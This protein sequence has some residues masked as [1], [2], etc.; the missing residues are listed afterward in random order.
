MKSVDKGSCMV[1]WDRLEHLAEAENH[2]N[3]NTTYKDVKFHEKVMAKLVEQS[4]K[5]FK[6][7]SKQ[8]ISYV[9]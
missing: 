6:K 8:N 9:V 2:L 5:M 3:D 7:L 1:V 4:N